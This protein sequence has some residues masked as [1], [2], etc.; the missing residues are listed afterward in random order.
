M[1]HQTIL[2][3][4]RLLACLVIA[5]SLMATVQAKD[6]PIV[7]TGRV[8]EIDDALLTGCYHNAFEGQVTRQADGTVKRGHQGIYRTKGMIYG[9]GSVYDRA[10]LSFS[11]DKAPKA[12]AK[13]V[14]TGLDDS[15]QKPNTVEI[16]LNGKQLHKG[17][18]LPNNDTSQT[19]NARYFVGWAEKT[20][21]IPA[22]I[23]K[24]GDNVLEIANLSSIWESAHWRHVII[25]KLRFEWPE[26]CTVTVKQPPPPIY[27]YGLNT[28]LE[29]NLWPTVNLGRI[30]L[31]KNGDIEFNFY[32]TYP[33][34]L[35]AKAAKTKGRPKLTLTLETAADLDIITVGGA[36][37]EKKKADGVNRY[38]LTSAVRSV[39]GSTPHP[40][41][42][43][44]V[45]MRAR[46]AFE[47]KSLTAWYA[48]GEIQGQKRTYPLRAV[49]LPEAKGEAPPFMLSIWGGGTPNDPERLSDFVDMI[50]RAG[51]NHMFTGHSTQLNQML[52][53]KKFQVYPRFGWFGH[54]FKVPDA[55]SDWAAR[56]PDGSVN[57]RD[58]C[59]QIILEHADD[60]EVGKFFHRAKAM[61]S[62]PNIDGLCVD[63]ETGAVWCWCDRCLKLFTKETGIEV[64]D[65][66]ELAGTG[67]HAHDYRE[68][69]RR[70]NRQLLN[71][72][73]QIMKTANPKLK[74]YALASASDMP[75]YWWDG[76]ARG[77]HSLRELVKFADQIGASGYFYELPGGLK[78]VLPILRTIKNFAV[79]E[80]RSVSPGMISPIAT[81]V[82]E[83]PRYRGVFM[84][85][86][87]LR[88]EVLLVA[89]G[90]GDN[91]SIFRGDCFD[92][93]Y[94]LATRRAMDEVKL[95][96]PYLKNGIDRSAEMKVTLEKMPKRRT[97]LSIAQNFMVRAEWRPDISYQYDVV[98][99]QRDARAI[100][101]ALLLFN[102]SSQP[103]SL[104]LRFQG[105]FD[106]AFEIS[107]LADGKAVG[108]HSRFEMESTGIVLDVPARDCRI[109][110]IESK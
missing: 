69:G 85:P 15:F 100:D 90:G 14:V 47:N 3:V 81:T 89:A 11:L 22:G 103:L 52:K 56:K 32:V 4:C 102:Y 43:I 60:K 98:Q 51:F 45:F 73:R 7:C 53:Q 40:V 21:S 65:R 19:G 64:K 68:F 35:L 17:E 72:V 107:S 83:T 108:K 104:R 74:Y 8:A 16:T 61:A 12:A 88:L 58:F 95:L 55:R 48:A 29:L 82:S 36:A 86:D 6:E 70:R 42:G 62:Q 13:L 94:Y 91:L 24:V 9:A 76:R 1:H 78:S 49:A 75:A 28:G 46:D 63:F 18:L 54:K 84:R 26:D 30:C 2:R 67:K 33:R 106:P 79:E 105:L 109:L 87:Y 80:G 10:R 66:A 5:M 25:D 110:R 38:S 57:K 59:P 77:R 44:R 50:S 37:F 92:G 99:I 31:V 41:Q 93:E 34:G 27:Y 39:K 71:R 101:R 20:V 97:D 23:L 96:Q